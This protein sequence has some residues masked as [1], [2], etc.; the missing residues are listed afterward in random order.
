YGKARGTTSR[1]GRRSR[2][3]VLSALG[4]ILLVGLSFALPLW[5]GRARYPQ[6][7]RDIATRAIDGARKEDSERW[8]PERFRSAITAY[9]AG[10][11]EGLRQRRRLI[12]FQDYA[13]TED[14]FYCAAQNANRAFREGKASRLGMASRAAEALGLAR[15]LVDEAQNSIRLVPVGVLPRQ[16]LQK[17][18][19]ALQEA[20]QHTRSGRFDLAYERAQDAQED[21][22][23]ALT[24]T[25]AAASRFVDSNVVS[26]W[27][28][29]VAQTV[30]ESKSRQSTALV[31]IKE[32]NRVDLYHA[33]RLK[34][35]Y[36]AD[37]G[38]NR[39]S[40]KLHQGDNATP[41]GR[42]HI[43]EKKGRGDSKYYK[44][45]V[46][47]YP[48]EADRKR[49]A[50]AKN[51]GMASKRVG[52]GS[53]IEIHGEGGR[54]QDWTYGCVALS[55]RDIDDLFTRVSVGT[56]VTIVGGDG[57]SGKFSDLARRLSAPPQ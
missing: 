13:L 28:R 20:T 39:L 2:I 30:A 4:L 56:P 31:V 57:Q 55:N 25:G 14:Q 26:E 52:P 36:S 18:K 15:S 46:L 33:G 11:A 9:E 10:V 22:Q 1:K 32:R 45:L 24:A 27:R 6:V 16:R 5:T 8:A 43:T 38:K 44:A 12:P 48:N 21:A 19:A 42:Y 51:A 53:L 41:E 29:L 23:W 34:K 35:S 49:L 54:G 47:N 17:S 7:Q 40:K 37:M 50:A 3:F